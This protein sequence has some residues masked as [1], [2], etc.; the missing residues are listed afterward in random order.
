MAIAFKDD[1]LEMDE[2]YEGKTYLMSANTLLTNPSEIDASRLN[3]NTSETKQSLTLLNPDVPRI[4]TGWENVLGKLNKNI[5]PYKQLDGHWIV[6]DI[7]RKFEKGEIF[8]IVI[9]N[10][11]TDTWDMIE[12]PVAENLIEKFGFVYNTEKMESLEIGDELND[13]IIYKSTAYDKHMNYMYGKNAKV[14]YST[15]TS[16]IEDAIRIRQGWADSVESV[17]I[18]CVGASVNMNHI[19]LNIYGDKHTYK[20]CPDFGEPIKNSMVFAFRPINNDHILYDFQNDNL[21][22]VYATDSD[23]YISE[24]KVSYIYD[25]DIYYN[26]TEPFPDTIFFKQL[27]GYYDEICQYADKMSEWAT[28]IKDSGS[29]YTQNIPFYKSKYQHWNNQ[30]RPWCGKEKNKPFGNMYIEFKTKSI[31]GLVPGSKLAGRYGKTP[32]IAVYK[33]TITA[34]KYCNV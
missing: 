2:K 20:V 26:N 6:K 10:P 33:I 7:I 34:E 18:D 32:I 11:D 27:K 4:S 5:T 12:K 17:E 30:N 14:Y 3:M 15:S 23:F 1:Y 8:T 24:A 13:E 19:P 21:R 16:T 22:K 29:N 25:I 28:K 9:Y 31:L